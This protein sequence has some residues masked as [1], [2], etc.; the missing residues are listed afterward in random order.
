M[1]LLVWAD[2]PSAL[3][4]SKAEHG[5]SLQAKPASYSLNHQTFTE[6]KLTSCLAS[7]WT[8]WV[9]QGSWLSLRLQGKWACCCWDY[10]PWHRVWRWRWLIEKDHPSSRPTKVHLVKVMVFPVVMYWCENWTIK[11]AEHDAFKLWC[12]RRLLRVPWTARRSNQSILKE[13]KPEYSVEG[14]VLKLNFDTLAAWWEEL[15]WWK[16][17]LMLEKFEGR[18]RRG[19]QRMRWLVGIT[20]SMNRSLSKLREMVKDK[21]SLAWCSPWGRKESDTTERLN[22]RRIYKILCYL[23]VLSLLSLSF[24]DI[25]WRCLKAWWQFHCLFF[26]S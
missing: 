13:I 21:G 5:S 8:F 26:V 25:K 1:R 12:W 20:D 14:L 6:V 10:T 4:I 7:G 18:R 24:P 3:I 23:F 15:T 11:K 22:N 19:W 2:Y 17:A 9:L 16:K